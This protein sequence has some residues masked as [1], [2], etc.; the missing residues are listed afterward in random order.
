MKWWNRIRRDDYSASSSISQD[1]HI[2]KNGRYQTQIMVTRAESSEDSRVGSNFEEESIGEDTNYTMSAKRLVTIRRTLLY[3]GISTCLLAIVM[4]L[5]VVGVTMDLFRA[6]PEASTTDSAS[7][8]NTNITLTTS[9]YE[10]ERAERLYEYL[11][12]VAAN[13]AAEFNDPV[14]PESLALAWMQYTDLLN[15]DPNDS[16]NHYRVDQ[17]FAL[18]TLWFQSDYEWLGQTNWLTG[19]ECTWE[20]VKCVSLFLDQN[21]TQA[22]DEGDRVVS[23]LYL[24]RNNLSGNLPVNLHLLK[25]LTSLNLS[26]NWIRGEIPK[27]YSSMIWLKEL[28]LYDNLLSQEVSL[29]FSQMSSLIDVNLSNNQ[30]EGTIPASIFKVASITRIRLD[31]NKFT[32]GIAKDIGNLANLCK[33]SILGIQI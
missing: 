19:N 4:I 22:S 5:F 7:V 33:R 30:L 25:S 32:G 18:L 28:R 23:E 2:V 14:S 17:R 10:Q 3:A 26:G 9:D 6:I 1:V 29:D 12:T 15:L 31:N 27:T 20:G 13:G 24:V 8:S 21:R 16:E 11:I